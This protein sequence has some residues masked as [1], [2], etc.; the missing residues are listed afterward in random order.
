MPSSAYEIKKKVE[1]IGKQ[2]SVIKGKITGVVDISGNP[3][4]PLFEAETA[5]L[6]VDEK[7]FHKIEE[8]REN[9]SIA[10]IDSSSRYLRDP[11]VNMVFVGL[12][13]YSN[14]KGIKVGPFDIDINFMAIGTFEELLKEFNP[15]S[16]VRVKNYVN[17]YFT[18]DYRIDD[19]ADELRLE[20]ENVGLKENRN[21]HDLVIVD[22][23]LFPTPLELSELELQSEGRKRHQEA[24]LQLTKD[25]ISILRN[26]VV[27]VVKR[28]ETSQKLYKVDK[29]KQLLGIR[30]PINDAEILNQIRIKTE[31]KRGLLGPFKIEFKSKY[32]D[33]PTRYA[34][35]LI[36]TNPI[37]MSSYFRIESLSL[38]SLEELTP[39]IVNRISE[40]LIPT[41]IE[42][43]DNLSKRVS[44]SLFIT[45]YQILS[46]IISVIHD[47]KLTYYNEVRSL[48]ESLLQ[49]QRTLLT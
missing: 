33:A 44:A 2:I 42:I 16:G 31:F 13:V 38:D 4:H 18:E 1:K 6:S 49:H 32:F 8:K 9:V 48:S 46:R 27:G 5:V 43:A 21:T 7:I 15:E 20:A 37:G 29:V 3:D 25:R 11:S 35:Y 14:I 30:Y 19:I 40:R 39:Y 28:L 22:G 17:K 26:N 10:S 47:D 12:G 41:Y 34:Y 36:L 23:P 24:Y 45:A